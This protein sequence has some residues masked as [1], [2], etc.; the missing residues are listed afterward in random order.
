M[1]IDIHIPEQLFR[2]GGLVAPA[3]IQPYLNWADMRNAD[4]TIRQLLPAYLEKE[5][6]PGIVMTPQQQYACDFCWSFAAATM[7][8]DR[9]SVRRY[10][11]SGKVFNPYLSPSDILSCMNCKNSGGVVSYC[12]KCDGENGE[13]GKNGRCAGGTSVCAAQFL[14]NVGISPMACKD[15]S[16]CANKGNATCRNVGHSAAE[17]VNRT[18]PACSTCAHN[19]SGSGACSDSIDSY[20]GKYKAL[21][22]SIVA[23]DSKEDIQLDIYKHGPVIGNFFVMG[24]AIGVLDSVAWSE[25]GNV[26]CRYTPDLKNVDVKGVPQA[27]EMYPEARAGPNHHA[28]NH[29]VVI[30]GWGE[31]PVTFPDLA[32]LPDTLRG[33]TVPI[34]YWIVRNTWGP[35][36]NN[37]G[38]WKHAMSNPALK[39]NMGIG[40]DMSVKASNGLKYGGVLSFL[41]AADPKKYACH[42]TGCVEDDNGVYPDSTCGGNNCTCPNKCSGHGTCDIT[43]GKCSCKF[44]YYGDDCSS[45][46]APPAG[47]CY[48]DLQW[49]FCEVGDKSTIE[50][51]KAKPMDACCLSDVTDSKTVSNCPAGWTSDPQDKTTWCSVG[52]LGNKYRHKCHRECA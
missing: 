27:I 37:T 34:K 2:R 15:F 46:A 44:G 16:W 13:F 7:L 39:I 35:R 9:F 14:S 1:S 28:G 3:Y 52:M 50:C 6:E 29:S 8:S 43:S 47:G 23:L 18:I 26:Y 32:D 45:C 38:Y 42:I 31:Q 49:P 20:A 48:A 17:Q 12:S 22:S 51:S 40:M 41:P 5:T 21:A 33:K 4:F 25:T 10:K 36:W 24:D 19:C 30:V 11:Q